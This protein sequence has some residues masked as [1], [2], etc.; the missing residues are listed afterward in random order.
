MRDWLRKI[1]LQEVEI[2][3]PIGDPNVPIGDTQKK[4]F[5][6]RSVKYAP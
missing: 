4:S 6:I 3:D 2:G 1:N 5:E